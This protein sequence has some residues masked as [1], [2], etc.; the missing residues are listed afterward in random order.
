MARTFQLVGFCPEMA[1]AMDGIGNHVLKMMGT[2]EQVQGQLVEAR[3]VYYSYQLY[4]GRGTCSIGCHLLSYSKQSLTNLCDALVCP[5][6]IQMLPSSLQSP[7]S[8]PSASDVR[9]LLK[10]GT[11]KY[12]Y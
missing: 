11:V 12:A 6:L 2:Y 1:L 4:T 3:P 8:V 7:L 5:E 9:V 10:F